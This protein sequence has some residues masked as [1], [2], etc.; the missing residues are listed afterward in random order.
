MKKSLCDSN[1]ID[2]FIKLAN[3][4]ETKPEDLWKLLKSKILELRNQFVPRGTPNGKPNWRTKGSI[5]VDTAVRDAIR[6]KEK[7]HRI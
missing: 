1:W 3:N 4:P 6:D 7:S 5:P 2:D